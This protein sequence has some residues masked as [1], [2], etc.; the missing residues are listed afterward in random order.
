MGHGEFLREP[1]TAARLK[2]EDSRATGV[3][4]ALGAVRDSTHLSVTALAAAGPYYLGDVEGLALLGVAVTDW[5]GGHQTFSYS[6][7]REHIVGSETA[8]DGPPGMTTGRGLTPGT[9]EATKDEHKGSRA[10]RAIRTRLSR[11][12]RMA[13]PAAT[14]WRR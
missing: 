6:D 11:A 7:P 2:E 14:S 1:N 8:R 9:T 4:Q 10:P 5:V 3:G 13:I 12:T